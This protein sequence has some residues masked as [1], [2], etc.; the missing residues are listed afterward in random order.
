VELPEAIK[1]VAKLSRTRN[2]P[3]SEDGVKDLAESLDRISEVIGIDPAHLVQLCADTLEFCPS[4]AEMWTLA[5]DIKEEL[6]RERERT[7]P[8]QSEQWR[9]QYGAPQAFDDSQLAAQWYPKVQAK[10]KRREQM[11][12]ELRAKFPAN[13]PD[14]STL[15]KAARELG[16]T[17]Y[18]DAWERSVKW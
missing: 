1:L 8:S 10:I 3:Q 5:R 9:R 6:R 17:E 2:F 11:W 4:D 12:R 13:W 18:A 16:Y 14:W 7:S 15:A